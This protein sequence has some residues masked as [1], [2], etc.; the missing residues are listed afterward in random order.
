MKRSAL[1]V[2]VT[3]AILT[4]V[5]ASTQQSTPAAPAGGGQANAGQAN[6]AQSAAPPQGKRPPQAKTQPEFDAYK[7][8]MANNNEGA[9]MEKSAD[10]F[11]AKYPDSEVRILLYEA[12]MRAYQSANNAEKMM[13]MGR[14]VLK[15]DADNPEALVGVAQVLA[16]RTRDTD[17]DKDQRYDEA[18]K[19]ARHALETVDTDLAIP[20]GTPQ[21]K[22][23]AYKSFMRSNANYVIGTVLYNQDKFADAEAAFHK[24]IDAYPSQPDPLVLL[25]LALALDKQDKY[26]DA[27]KYADQ[28]VQMTQ[29]SS[30]LG[31]M[32]RKER[33]RLAAL[34]KS[35]VP[36]P[37][38]NASP[39]KN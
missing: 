33:E 38:S 17:L 25:R 37:A 35:T 39:Q 34:T 20:A 6:T 4:I 14:K 5:A 29:D 27:L 16:E 13:D 10:D 2:I 32:A 7:A 26:S 28:A 8:A 21:D 15:L 30:Q 9:A 11:A 22:I 1:V 36:P 12:A 23:D 31:Q 18:L 19:L 24:A 3:V